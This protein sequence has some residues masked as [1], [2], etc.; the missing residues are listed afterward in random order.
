VPQDI[1][2]LIDR[3]YNTHQIVIREFRYREGLEPV[4]YDPAL[5]DS[6]WLLDREFT[7]SRGSGSVM[8]WF[9]TVVEIPEKVGGFDVSGSPAYLLANIDD[10]GEIWVDGQIRAP[11]AGFNVD[12]RALLSEQARPGDRFQVAVLAINGY[13]ARPLGGIFIRYA[14]VQFSALESVRGAA[15]GVIDELRRVERRLGPPGREDESLEARIDAAAAKIDWSAAE[16]GDK[17]RFIR[18][19]NEA[20]K[21]L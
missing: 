13:L 10:Y 21:G 18:S 7:R 1:P 17:L 11:I 8:G 5:D 19:L 14:R 20:R 3:L 4:A 12:Q 6:Q 16:A 15:E 9:R 2:A